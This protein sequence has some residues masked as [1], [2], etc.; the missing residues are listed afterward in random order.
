M[1]QIMMDY[2]IEGIPFLRVYAYEIVFELWPQLF[3]TCLEVVLSQ[4]S[5]GRHFSIYSSYLSV[6]IFFAVEK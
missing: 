5:S 3:E 1:Y 6:M 4:F 2:G